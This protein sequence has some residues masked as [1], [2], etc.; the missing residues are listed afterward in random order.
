FH[1]YLCRQPKGGG[2]EIKMTYLGQLLFEEGRK[3]EQKNTE[4][5]RLRAEKAEME[6][7]KAQEELRELKEQFG[8][9]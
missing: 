3:E 8:L 2:M 5:E 9:N 7:R 6:A 1:C 4:R